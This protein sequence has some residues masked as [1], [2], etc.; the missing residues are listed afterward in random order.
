MNGD[1]IEILSRDC[2]MRNIEKNCVKFKNS[3]LTK[4]E[5]PEGFLVLST[6]KNLSFSCPTNTD[7]NDVELK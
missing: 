4:F 7:Q 6:K 3:N 1:L 5:R 2:V